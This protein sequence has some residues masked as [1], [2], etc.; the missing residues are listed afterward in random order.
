M[1]RGWSQTD[2]AEE[3]GITQSTV[4]AI[5]SGQSTIYMRRVLELARATGIS[6]T[7]TWNDDDAPR[8]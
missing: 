8:D 2:L 3:L 4:S 1:A 6:L 7:A 5:E